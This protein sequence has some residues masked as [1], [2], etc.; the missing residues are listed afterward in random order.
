[1]YAAPAR[2]KRGGVYLNYFA[3]RVR[4]LNNLV[5]Y[6]VIWIVEGAK[7]NPSIDYVMIYVAV[8]HPTLRIPQSFGCG[9]WNESEST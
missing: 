8:V 2:K 1:M 6:S 5:G 3:I 9:Y 7:N 4:A